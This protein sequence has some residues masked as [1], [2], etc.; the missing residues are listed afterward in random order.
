MEGKTTKAPVPKAEPEGPFAL[1]GMQVGAETKPLYFSLNYDKLAAKLGVPD[2]KQ[3]VEGAIEKVRA[4]ARESYGENLREWSV[5]SDAN[6]A[7]FI[8]SEGSPSF[9]SIKLYH[10]LQMLDVH[11]YALPVEIFARIKSELYGGQ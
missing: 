5:A 9:I 10:K 6:T 11:T 1:K 3:A 7:I 8:S 4:I 2:G